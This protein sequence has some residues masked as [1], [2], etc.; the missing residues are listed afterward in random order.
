MSSIF[1]SIY[2]WT[3]FFNACTCMGIHVHVFHDTY[4]IHVYCLESFLFWGYFRKMFVLFDLYGHLVLQ[5]FV[6]VVLQDLSLKNMDLLALINI[7]YI[8]NTFE[9]SL[10]LSSLLKFALAHLSSNPDHPF[11]PFAKFCDFSRSTGPIST[12]CW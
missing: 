4:Y 2:F 12:V 5:L 9:K 8:K 6:Q 10:Q 11:Y 1:T 7:F 3:F